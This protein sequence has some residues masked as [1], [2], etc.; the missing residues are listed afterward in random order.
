MKYKTGDLSKIL[1]VSANTIRRFTE[2]GY[3]NPD[4]NTDNQY[5]FF[6]DEDV[7]K[8][9]YISKYRK[10]GFGHEEIGDILNSDI[11]KNRE[12]YR[13]KKDELDREIKR[14]K[15]IRH[16]LKDDITMMD[17]IEKYGDSFFE[18]ESTDVYYVTYKDTTQIKGDADRRKQLHRF[19][20]DLP[21][22]EYV[23]IIRKENLLQKRFLCE[24]AVSVRSL[25][26][27]KNDVVFESDAVEYYPRMHSVCRI[28]RL[29]LNL[30]KE[31]GEQQKIQETILKDYDTYMEEH[32][33]R[34]AG[35][36]VGVKIGFSKEEG[37][38]MQYVVLGI[39]VEKVDE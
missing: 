36:A 6:G 10:I 13:Q 1:G 23:Y 2:K 18:M 9:V 20:Y 15:Y 7:E 28:L 33:Y 29:P 11:V 16:M 17:A 27:K 14:L 32:G 35:D 12:V 4:R 25:W 24:E 31:G 19:I 5:R 30:L 22:I 3:L 39:P 8:M 38:D 21:E 34:P 26:A 37:R